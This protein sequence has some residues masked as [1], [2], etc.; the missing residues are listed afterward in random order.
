[1]WPHLL[2][3]HKYIRTLLD[4]SSHSPAVMISRRSF[5]EETPP[6]IPINRLQH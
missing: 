1:M 6:H 4:I 2:S 5:V 3:I